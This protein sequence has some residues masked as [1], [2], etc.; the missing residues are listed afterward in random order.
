MEARTGARPSLLGPA[1]ALNPGIHRVWTDFLATFHYEGF[2]G[3]FSLL[4]GESSVMRCLRGILGGAMARHLRIEYPGAVYH[5]TSRG[6][7]RKAIFRDAADR[8]AFLAF[9]GKVVHRFG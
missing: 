9:L 7:E 4:G 2:G 5:L 1:I 3:R 6:N 8:E